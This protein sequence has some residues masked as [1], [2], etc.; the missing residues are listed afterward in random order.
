MQ[1]FGVLKQV[2]HV[3]TTGLK[4][5]SVSRMRVTSFVANSLD[6]SVGLVCAHVSKMPDTRWGETQLGVYVMVSASTSVSDMQAVA[7]SFGMEV[8]TYKT[9]PCNNS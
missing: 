3:V 7:C 9:T 4:G 6:H 8:P 2:V 1:S 5:L